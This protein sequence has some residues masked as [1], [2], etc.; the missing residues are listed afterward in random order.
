MIIRRKKEGSWPHRYRTWTIEATDGDIALLLWVFEKAEEVAPRDG[1]NESLLEVVGDIGK[2]ESALR[3]IGG[4][5]TVGRRSVRTKPREASEQIGIEAPGN[6][7][8]APDVS[9]FES[10]DGEVPAISSLE[11]DK[12]AGSK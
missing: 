5:L 11:E 2:I 3:N 10:A 7:G 8:A 12:K 4:G 6:I 1:A 9:E